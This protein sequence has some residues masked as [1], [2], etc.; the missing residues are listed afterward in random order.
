MEME[1]VRQ[2]AA[3]TTSQ[4]RPFDDVPVSTPTKNVD[5]QSDAGTPL[6]VVSSIA[7]PSPLK[8]SSQVSAP[9][10]TN[11]STTQLAGS[12]HDAQPAKRRKLTDK[13]KEEKRLEKEAKEKARAEL[14]AA[15]DEEKRKKEEEKQKKNSE[16][17]EKRRAKEL[18][19]QRKEEEKLKK[20]RVWPPPPTSKE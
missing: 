16:R 2:T 18:E 14:K 6:T 11:G 9:P 3:P 13:E 10:S 15:K 17:E 19:Q 5:V 7:T 8:K 4:K 12:T 20:E 1:D